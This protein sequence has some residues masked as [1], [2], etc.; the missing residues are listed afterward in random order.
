MLIDREIGLKYCDDEDFYEEILSDFA[1]ESAERMDTLRSSYGSSDWETYKIAVHSL[2]SISLLI[3][4]VSL[5]GS[6]KKHQ[7]AAADR[8]IA[9]IKEN[10]DSLMAEYQAVLEEIRR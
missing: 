9:F 2:K 4:A 8:D 5:S 6:A 7:D 1:D 10:F 3:G